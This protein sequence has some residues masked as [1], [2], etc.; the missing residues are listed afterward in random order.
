MIPHTPMFLWTIF[1]KDLV[2]LPESLNLTLSLNCISPSCE[3]LF[4]ANLL[5]LG[6][7]HPPETLL[8]MTNKANFSQ[9]LGNKMQAFKGR[10]CS[11]KSGTY[12]KSS[13]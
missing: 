6:T 11:H 9:N 10:N 7:A 1:G 12:A 4:V 8:M 13:L 3:N 5:C 2:I